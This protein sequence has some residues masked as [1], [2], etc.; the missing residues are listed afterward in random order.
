MKHRNPL[1]GSVIGITP[2]SFIP[3]YLHAFYLGV[4]KAFAAEFIW[5][6]MLCNVWIDRR[7]RTMDEF[8]DV[9]TGMIFQTLQTWYYHQ[10]LAGP[11]DN[12][13]VIETLTVG[14]FR[15]HNK[16]K[17]GLEATDTNAF[18]DLAFPC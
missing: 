10:H 9:C 18:F 4:L 3:D 8:I 17:F 14:M 16:R 6:L 7:G 15:K 1:F 5:E 13:T 2:M 12:L 11:E